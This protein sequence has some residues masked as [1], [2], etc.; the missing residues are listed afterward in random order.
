[1]GLGKLEVLHDLPDIDQMP[2]LIED[3]E[4]SVKELSEA[5]S[6]FVRQMRYEYIEKGDFSL[7]RK[8]WN[9]YSVDCSNRTTHAETI[10]RHVYES[11]VPYQGAI[12]AE[13]GIGLEK[14]PYL[15]LSRSAEE[16]ELMRSLKRTM[17]P[18]NI[19]NPGKVFSLT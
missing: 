3:H 18:K 2:H 17:D 6:R 1:M 5:E 13:H 8:S 12:S 16:I 15:S 4:F 19:L 10:E 14:K 9:P 11:L 7:P